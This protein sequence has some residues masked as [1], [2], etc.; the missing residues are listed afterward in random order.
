MLIAWVWG[1]YYRFP[2]DQ[3]TPKFSMVTSLVDG[4]LF[5]FPW[6]F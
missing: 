6:L 2:F 3:S 4:C 5:V 1:R